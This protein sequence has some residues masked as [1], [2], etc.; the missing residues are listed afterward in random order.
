MIKTLDNIEL[1]VGNNTY[2]LL[3]NSKDYQLWYELR[4]KIEL[5]KSAKIEKL[6]MQDIVR[7][8]N[9]V[10]YYDATQSKITRVYINNIL[11]DKVTVQDTTGNKYMLSDIAT[12]MTILGTNILSS[13]IYFGNA[14]ILKNDKTILIKIR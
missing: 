9:F 1:T 3:L 2:N 5:H 14:D 11:G 10:I 12:K 8:D 13:K 6:F 7:N 4:N